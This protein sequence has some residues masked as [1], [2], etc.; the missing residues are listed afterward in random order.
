MTIR[1]HLNAVKFGGTNCVPPF[2]K[3]LWRNQTSDEVMVKWSKL[4]VIR[5]IKS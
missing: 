5:E 4:L 1:N 2:G 3:Y